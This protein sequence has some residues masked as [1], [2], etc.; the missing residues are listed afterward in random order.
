M[1]KK[2]N[3][4]EWKDTHLNEKKDKY[5]NDTKGYI[6]DVLSKMSRRELER[7]HKE[8]YDS[9]GNMG[10]DELLMKDII[11]GKYGS[12]EAQHWSR[13]IDTL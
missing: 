11:A 6:D 2:F 10:S 13:H 8:Y 9:S 1:D 4:K 12:R 3:I 7:E 5:E